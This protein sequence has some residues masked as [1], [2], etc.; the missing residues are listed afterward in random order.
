MGGT[1]EAD[2][3]PLGG[4]FRYMELKS[5]GGRNW[6]AQDIVSYKY[7]GAFVGSQLMTVCVCERASERERE[8]ESEGD[9]ET[10]RAR[11]KVRERSVCMCGWVGGCVRVCVHFYVRVCGVCVYVWWT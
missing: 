1:Y 9:S 2:A 7:S 11:A 8:R 3:L 4:L 6:R 10:A 5:I